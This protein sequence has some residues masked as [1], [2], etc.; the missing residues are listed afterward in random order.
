MIK[1]CRNGHEKTPENVNKY[2]EC[3]KCTNARSKRRYEKSKEYFNEY[4]EANKDKILERS[5]QR[6]ES[7]KELLAD[8]D[9]K[10]YE[11]NK[12]KIKERSKQYRVT[13]K[14]EIAQY[15]LQ[16]YKNNPMVRRIDSHRHRAKIK[17]VGGKLSKGI[18]TKLL[19]LQK[20]K[21]RICKIKI[22]PKRMHLDH[23][24]PIT[25]GGP[26]TD[27]NIQL[28]CPTCNLKKG[29]KLP[30]IHAQELGMLFY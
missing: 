22:T 28:L 9:R 8:S 26:N 24:I 29:A 15:K 1:L 23:I 27:N 25:K 17:E 10:Y 4:Y 2:G 3:R 11:F 12:D 20:G 14:N 18:A 13:N 19:N 21:C 16:Y 5:K 7:K 6:R 30:E